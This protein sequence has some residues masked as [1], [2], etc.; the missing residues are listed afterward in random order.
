MLRALIAIGVLCF[1][2]MAA[3]VETWKVSSLDWP[4][5]SGKDLP[6]GGVGIAV[7]RAALKAEA[8]GLDVRFFPWTR[9]IQSAKNPSYA[10]FY[11]VWP[12][13]VQ[14]GFSSSQVFFKSPVGF[15]EPV[16]RPLVWNNLRDLEG[17][18][19]GTV[20]DYGNTPEFMRLVQDGVIKTEIVLDDLT[21]IRKVAGGRIDAAFIDLHNLAYYLKHDARDL[22]PR[23]QANST[24]ID[25]KFLVFAVNANFTNDQAVE[26]LN[27]GLSKIDSEQIIND[28]FEKYGYIRQ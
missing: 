23:V 14:R 22:A 17:K 4:P 25:D 10:G 18:T 16:T 28:Y 19:I 20:Q 24:V 11:P 12:E 27:R 8:I 15:V 13:D 1:S 2:T 6:E 9:A 21:N 3:A 26:I 7:L 5:F